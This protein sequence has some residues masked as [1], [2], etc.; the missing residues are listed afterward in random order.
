MGG[1]L[2]IHLGL[3]AS[4]GAT[5]PEMAARAQQDAARVGRRIS[6]WAGRLTRFDGA[7]DLM[8]LNTSCE[9]R[10][11][12]RPT[13]GRA[14]SWA[15]EAETDTNGLV[16]PGLLDARLA[17]EAG[18]KPPQS[19]G[20]RGAE[21][22]GTARIGRRWQVERTGGL[23]LDLDGLAKGWLADRALALLAGYPSAIVAADGD[24]AVRVASGDEWAIGVADPTTDG[25][26]VAV[27]R[28]TAWRLPETFGLATSGTTVHRW[29]HGRRSDHHLIDPATGRPARTDLIQATVLAGSAR[30]AEVLAKAA[31]VLGSEAGMRFLEASGAD[32]AIVVTENGECMAITRTLRWLAPDDAR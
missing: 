30:R 20:G 14:L 23:Q 7:S 4:P 26:D 11:M 31:V 29:P 27:M 2:Q 21:A 12:V 9:S 22:W 28:L 17:A 8:R 10:V 1:E 6:A 24:I 18:S 13:L 32:G 5:D 16:T 3:A 19:A 25:A 15:K